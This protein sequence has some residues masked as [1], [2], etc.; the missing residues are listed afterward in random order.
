MNSV[1][2]QLRE[3]EDRL[4]TAV[5]RNAQL[6]AAILE[7]GSLPASVNSTSAAQADLTARIEELERV[8]VAE[9]SVTLQTQEERLLSLGTEVERIARLHSTELAESL[10][11]NVL[12]LATQ[13]E[14]NVSDLSTQVEINRRLANTN[15]DNLVT[16]RQ[17]LDRHEVEFN[18]QM[19]LLSQ[20]VREQ[21]IPLARGLV[22]HLYEESRRMTAGAQEL[23][24]FARKVDPYKFTHLIPGL[25]DGAE[26]AR[27]ADP[28]G[29][30]SGQEEPENKDS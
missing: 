10:E 5:R 20:Y 7:L 29:A 11:A 13:L 19:K 22:T 26:G 23:E 4:G 25:G 12:D 18:R 9:M 1:R 27:T 3:T 15:R 28:G 21:F 8:R 2:L 30:E 17:A 24:E 16:V 6:E 14:K